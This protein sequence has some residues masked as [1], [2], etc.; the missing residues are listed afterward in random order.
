MK[1]NL[2]TFLDDLPIWTP[3]TIQ[4]HMEQFLSKDLQ[5]LCETT[6]KFIRL[7]DLQKKIQSC[8]KE[9]H[10][11][12]NKLKAEYDRVFVEKGEFAWSL[13]GAILGIGLALGTHQLDNIL[14]DKSENLANEILGVSE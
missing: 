12:S 3:K 5:D 9:L 11:A 2:Q 4:K 6:E 1:H 10:I 7:V 13:H 8:K 14:K